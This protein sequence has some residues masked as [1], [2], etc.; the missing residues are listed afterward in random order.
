VQRDGTAINVWVNGTPMISVTDASYVGSL[1]WGV[2]LLAGA[3]DATFPPV[4]GQMA[5]DYDN[6]KLYSR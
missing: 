3:N 6:I 2:A 1:K 4:G 5:I